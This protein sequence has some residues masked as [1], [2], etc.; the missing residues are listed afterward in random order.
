MQF[1][2][3]V[4]Y[5][6][7]HTAASETNDEDW[8]ENSDQIKREKGSEEFYK[9]VQK[10]NNNID[11]HEFKN[12]S[13]VN[14]WAKFLADK[15]GIDC[16][17]NGY[18]GNSIQQMFWE[19]KRDMLNGTLTDADLIIVGL[20]SPNRMIYFHEYNQITVHLG[21][22]DQ[23]PDAV[24]KGYRAVV[25]FNNDEV[26]RFNYAMCLESL[27]RLA[28][29]KLANRLFF[30]KCDPTALEMDYYNWPITSAIRHPKW[31]YD[32]INPMYREFDNS[33]YMISK[34]NLYQD[35]DRSDLH[36][37]GHVKTHIHQNWANHLYNELVKK[38]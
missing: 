13:K 20:T 2:R 12:Y 11:W 15:L 23:W 38:I 36:G 26:I 27:A 28:E 17:N 30:V 7:S 19:I 24:K 32:I 37:L 33:P 8:L 31:Y 25:E 6:C 14:S 18:P 22:H 3:L 16:L 35:A 5:G 21:F 1:N 29:T 9:L 4:A 34:V 10:Y